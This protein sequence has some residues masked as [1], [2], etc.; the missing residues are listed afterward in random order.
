MASTH[1]VRSGASLGTSAIIHNFH[2]FTAVH[3]IFT[4]TTDE[5]IYQIGNVELHR[6]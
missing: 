6:Q 5:G 4:V 3:A 2:L 1:N